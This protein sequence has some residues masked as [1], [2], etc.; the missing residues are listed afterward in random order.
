[1]TPLEQTETVLRTA[2]ESCDTAEE[3][4]RMGVPL[5]RVMEELR[6][7]GLPPEALAE[8]EA[9]VTALARAWEYFHQA[10]DIL[11][12][13]HRHAINRLADAKCNN[14]VAPS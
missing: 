3:A 11:Y 9:A 7:S 4:L 6:A 1:M 5:R 8:T 10:S 2:L 13:A 12:S 14:L